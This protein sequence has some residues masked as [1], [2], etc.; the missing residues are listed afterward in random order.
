MGGGG[1]RVDGEGGG[2]REGEGWREKGGV[3]GGGELGIEGR[4][5]GG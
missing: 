5:E 3:E 4:K 1:L 2:W